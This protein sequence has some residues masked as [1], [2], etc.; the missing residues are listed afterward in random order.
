M[1][2]QRLHIFNKLLT[3]QMDNTSMSLGRKAFI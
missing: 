2:N 3:Y 1:S